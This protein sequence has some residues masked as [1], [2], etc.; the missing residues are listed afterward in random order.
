MTLSRRPSRSRPVRAVAEQS[1]HGAYVWRRK[2]QFERSDEPTAD[3]SLNR[4]RLLLEFL[5]DGFSQ[6]A[7]RVEGLDEPSSAPAIEPEAPAGTARYENVDTFNRHIDGFLSNWVALSSGEAPTDSR[8]LAFDDSTVAKLITDFF[9]SKLRPE[10]IQPN[11]PNT[12]S[13]QVLRNFVRAKELGVPVE[14]TSANVWRQ[15]WPVDDATA[16]FL[17]RAALAFGVPLTDIP[18]D[19]STL[20]QYPQTPAL[21]EARP[22][23][24][25]TNGYDLHGTL[26][27]VY[28]SLIL[29][30][31]LAQVPTLKPGVLQFL[32]EVLPPDVGTFIERSMPAAPVAGAD[33]PE[34]SRLAALPPL[35]DRRVHAQERLGEYIIGNGPLANDWQ[36]QGYRALLDSNPNAFFSSAATDA[37]LHTLG[38][39]GLSYS[40]W[41]GEK[42]NR[43][44]IIQF[45][46]RRLELDPAAAGPIAAELQAGS[47]P[48]PGSGPRVLLRLA[49][50]AGVDPQLVKV[51]DGAGYPAN[52]AKVAQLAGVPRHQLI[53]PLD[54][55]A[56]L[57][58]F[59]LEMPGTAQARFDALTQMQGATKAAPSFEEILTAAHRLLNSGGIASLRLGELSDAQRES[60]WAS[61][62]ADKHLGAS[63][64]LAGLFT[65][66]DL[67]GLAEA[68]NRAGFAERE[69]TTWVQAA[70]SLQGLKA[71]D[72]LFALR[73]VAGP[74]PDFNLFPLR[75]TLAS[76]EL[77]SSKELAPLFERWR[78][79]DAAEAIDVMTEWSVIRGKAQLDQLRDFVR[80]AFEHQEVSLAEVLEGL[81]EKARGWVWPDSDLSGDELARLKTAAERVIVNEGGAS[82]AQAAAR[83]VEEIQAVP[84]VVAPSKMAA[85]LLHAIQHDQH[86]AALSLRQADALLGGV[87]GRPWAPSLRAL[88]GALSSPTTPSA[89]HDDASMLPSSFGFTERVPTIDA[90]SVDLGGLQ[91]KY[92]RLFGELRMMRLRLEM[93]SSHDY[94]RQQSPTHDGSEMKEVSAL[95]DRYL[96][97]ALAAAQSPEAKVAVF[98]EGRAIIEQFAKWYEDLRVRYE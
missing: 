10:Y 90:S 7:E 64:V 82:Q 44:Q 70:E 48:I 21:V 88:A 69:V 72:Q 49:K 46:A 93:R 47:I 71:D 3:Q 5:R 27:G 30:K 50:A 12:D 13:L 39:E 23:S 98:A 59:F 62:V 53:E 76:A 85:V 9:H 11:P 96:G 57:Q 4:S 15:Q 41:L 28:D 67:S 2:L 91:T 55:N 20:D 87:P 8:L 89:S 84:P 60:L 73:A 78:G 66:G 79:P 37:N 31:H 80:V 77:L 74:T 1:G 61:L 38:S 34:A 51:T 32:E 40:Y 14:V 29:V 36:G 68:L 24:L 16:A 75:A 54:L 83:L 56:V 65:E 6:T 63:A 52:L 22:Q 92:P 42:R 35:V 97:P 43:A 17:R 25:A 86:G 94:V 81:N 58:T 33:A 19:G 95:L 45:L 26:E 18:F